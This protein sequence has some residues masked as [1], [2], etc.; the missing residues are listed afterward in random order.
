MDSWLSDVAGNAIIMTYGSDCAINLKLS[1]IFRLAYKKL[2]NHM[3]CFSKTKQD[4]HIMCYL[5][6]D[7]L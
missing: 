7:I 1:V 2:N 6:G 5:L 4:Y 3:L